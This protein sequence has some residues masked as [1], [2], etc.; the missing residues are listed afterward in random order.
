ML[1]PNCQFQNPEGTLVCQNCQAVLEVPRSQLKHGN[2]RLIMFV[3][4]VLVI[5]GAGIFFALYLN[6]INKKSSNKVSETIPETDINVNKPVSFFASSFASY[7]ETPVNI[8]P[9]VAHY[10]ISPDLG[11]ISNRADFKFSPQAQQLIIQN[12]FVVKPAQHLEFFEIYSAN[13]DEYIPSFITTDSMLHSYHLM[14]DYLLRNLEEEKLNAELKNLNANMLSETLSQYN[15]LKGTQWEN[16]AKRN[17]GFFAVGSKLLDPEVVIPREV[18]S[19]VKQEL[20]FIEVHQGIN[21][22]PVMNVGMAKDVVFDTPQGR[23]GLAA[24]K[25]DYSQY[26]P[27]GHY[28]KSDLLKRY[29]KTMMWYGRL[30]FRFKN[31]DEIKSALLITMG[32]NNKEENRVSWNTIYEPINFFVGKSDDITYYQLAD[33][34]AKVY[35][36]NITIQSV[37]TDNSKFAIFVESTKSLEPPQINSVP[38]FNAAIQPDREKEIKGFRFMGQRFT[39]DSSIFQRLGDPEVPDRMLPKGLDVPAAM[40]SAEALNI[41]EQMRET[42]YQNYSEN[43]GEMKLFISDL[44]TDTWTQNLYWGWLYALQ[45]LL[46]EKPEGYPPFM[47]NLSWVRKE[48]NTFLGSWTELKRDTILYVKEPMLGGGGGFIPE[49]KDIRGYVEP[50]PYVYARLASLLK[51]T[52]EGLESRGLL[53]DHANN[54]EQMEQLAL[55]LKIISEKELNNEKLT[56]AEYELI[57]SYGNKIYNIWREANPEANV[58]VF[59]SPAMIVVDVAS[60]PIQVLEE[61]TGYVSEIY[62]VAPIDGKLSLVKGGVYSYYEFAWPI[63]DRLTDETWRELLDSGKAPDLPKWVSTFLVK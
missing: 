18:E 15:A 24:L 8:S 2:R 40:G 7:A 14:F 45:P 10:S 42:R 48:L 6:Y 63:S 39:I 59:Q 53:N 19:E 51:V 17:L 25:E 35:G 21:E 12:G 38:I 46:T 32:L 49:E 1:C 62:A 50:N 60:N 16:A 23:L 5:I 56:D 30:T 26:V 31:E 61:A 34:L 4:V 11:N 44:T 36:G 37:T 43:M 22:S 52:R 47:R 3:L 55:S 28:S 54:L 29:F 33:L 27:R 9:K 58:N 41:L 20:A 57:R 13:K